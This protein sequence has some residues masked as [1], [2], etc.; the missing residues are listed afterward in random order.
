VILQPIQTI[1]TKEVNVTGLT[2]VKV[3]KRVQLLHVS[4]I[5]NI[6]IRTGFIVA[7]DRGTEIAATRPTIVRTHTASRAFEPLRI[8][9][10]LE[11]NI[12]F[13]RAKFTESI[14]LE[15]GTVGRKFLYF[16]IFLWAVMC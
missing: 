9:S 10:F 7:P 6:K 14:R 12:S 5:I 3:N 1:Q 8:E 16:A 2:N 11:W 4:N 15:W 13:E